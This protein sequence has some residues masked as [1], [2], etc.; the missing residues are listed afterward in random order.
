MLKYQLY[1]HMN[2]PQ[3]PALAG[4]ALSAPQ[5]GAKKYLPPSFACKRIP[6]AGS[7]KSTGPGG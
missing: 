2:S 3:P 7:T 5:R 1:N 4:Q 6:P